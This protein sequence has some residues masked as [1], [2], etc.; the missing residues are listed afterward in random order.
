MKLGI[1]IDMVDIVRIKHLMRTT[2]FIDRCFSLREK[3]MFREKG[4][5]LYQ[6]VAGNFCA[7]EACAK[8]LGTGFTNIS[9]VEIEVLRDEKGKPYFAFNGR[10]SYL[11]T[12]ARFEVSITHTDAMAAATVLIQPFSKRKQEENKDNNVNVIE[13]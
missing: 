7:K 9:L 11:D 2:S 5:G 10:L 13:T 1:G 3:E 4:K 6:T 8:A 12:K